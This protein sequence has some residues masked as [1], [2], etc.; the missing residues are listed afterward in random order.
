MRSVKSFVGPVAVVVLGLGLSG[1]HY[2]GHTG[3]GPKGHTG[4]ALGAAGGGLAAAATGTG[5]AGIAAG[6][7]LGGILGGAVGHSLDQRDEELARYHTQ[8]GL[9]YAPSGD[10]VYWENPDSGNRGYMTPYPAY[11]TPQ[12]N[13]CREFQQ[14]IVVGGQPQSGYGTACRQPDGSWQII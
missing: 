4:A 14:T 1:C 5:P 3:L 10:R 6:V 13:Y 7:L 12:G 11:Q 8:Q 2:F 9:E